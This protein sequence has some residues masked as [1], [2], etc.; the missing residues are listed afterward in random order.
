M[1]LRTIESSR[2]VLTVLSIGSLNLLAV[3]FLPS[4]A[5]STTGFVPLACAGNRL[6]SRSVAAWLS[7]PGSVR[8]LLSSWPAPRAQK[9]MPRM[10]TA[11]T[12]RTIQ[13]RRAQ[14]PPNQYSGRVMRA[15]CLS[16]RG[17]APA[18]VCHQPCEP[19]PGT[20]G[21]R[22]RA[23]SGNLLPVAIALSDGAGLRW[24]GLPS[25]WPRSSR[26]SVSASA[27]KRTPPNERKSSAKSHLLRKVA[28]AARRSTSGAAWPTPR[29]RLASRNAR[30]MSRLVSRSRIDSRLSKRS[31]PRA[32]AISTFANGPRKYIRV[33]TSVRPFSWMRPPSGRNPAAAGSCWSGKTSMPSISPNPT[34]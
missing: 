21:T 1:A 19:R 15:L 18:T 26:G 7:V 2:S 27:T 22:T 13:W 24:R 8:S 28:S 23:A 33:G 32:S 3:S 14:K 11:Q 25:R 16:H 5:T 9:P 17:G 30:C 12:A 20:K 6:S 29:Y 34:I 10:M 31:L 4:G